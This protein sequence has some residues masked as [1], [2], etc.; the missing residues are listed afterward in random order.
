MRDEHRRFTDISGFGDFMDRKFGEG[1][2]DH[3]ISIAPKVLYLFLGRRWE[4][5]DGTESAIGV[6]FWDF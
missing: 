5:D 6:T 1:I 3:V 2:A 4:G